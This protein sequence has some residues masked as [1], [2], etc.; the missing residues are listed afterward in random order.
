MNKIKGY[1]IDKH[2][3]MI[4][5]NSKDFRINE[6]EQIVVEEH[7]TF[8]EVKKLYPNYGKSTNTTN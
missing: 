6:Y 3:N 8:E 4:D 1:G 2:G 7:L 5:I